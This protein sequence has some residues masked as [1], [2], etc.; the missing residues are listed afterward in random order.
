[1]RCTSAPRYTSS[2]QNG[3]RNNRT[4][5]NYKKKPTSNSPKFIP[6]TKNPKLSYKML[7]KGKAS[8]YGKEF[9][10]KKTANGEI[11]N[12]HDLTAAH[13]TLPLGTTVKV[14]NIANNKSVIVR[15]N[16][17][18]PYIQG[19]IIDLSYAAAKKLD[20]IGNGTAEVKI[21]VIKFGDN[22]YKK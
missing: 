14:I 5:S 7:W 17:R 15:I 21:K 11:Y 18:G 22:S 19:R 16:D 1:M 2:P 9:N 10:G 8:Y 12:M 3:R 6:V 13:R 4:S 20:Y